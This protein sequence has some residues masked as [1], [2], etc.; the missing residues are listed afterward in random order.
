MN[1]NRGSMRRWVSTLLAFAVTLSLL[2]TS[3]FS[4]AALAAL[5]P[6][7]TETDTE[8]HKTTAEAASASNKPT[9]YIDFLGDS[10]R[11]YPG[12]GS[13]LPTTTDRS[14]EQS[15][16]KGGTWEKYSSASNEVFWIGVGIDKMS[17]FELAKSG[18]GLSGLELGFYY[19]PEFVEPYTNGD[20][21]ATLSSANLGNANTVNQWDRD[22]YYIEEA[23]TELNP[24]TDPDTQEYIA[25]QIPE[26]DPVAYEEFDPA[27]GGWRMLYVSLERKLNDAGTGWASNAANR[28]ADVTSENDGT[29]YY[30]MMLPFTLKKYDPNKAICFRLARNASLFSMGGGTYGAETYDGT[31]GASTFGAWEGETRTPK[32]NLK[33]MFDFEGDLNIFT[34][35][36]ELSR[37]FRATLR[38]VN[39]GGN[40]A[41]LYPSDD[42]TLY[43]NANGGVISGLAEGTAMTL[44]ISKDSSVTANITITT[45]DGTVAYSEVTKGEKYTFVMPRDNVTVTVT[46]VTEI[47][48]DNSD[49]KAKLILSGVNEKTENTADMGGKDKDGNLDETNMAGDPVKDTISVKPGETVTVE[50]ETHPDY[51]ARVEVK[52]KANNTETVTGPDEEGKY[53]FTMPAA[54][55]DVTVTYSLLPTHI[56]VLSVEQDAANGSV[57]NKARLSFEDYSGATADP[58][59]IV[60]TD[61]SGSNHLNLGPIPENRTVTLDVA[62][63]ENYTVSKVELWT[64][65]ENEAERHKVRDL[66]P[67]TEKTEPTDEY[68]WTLTFPMPDYPVEVYVG[69]TKVQDYDAKLVLVGDGMG[70]AVMTGKSGASDANTG[71]GTSNTTGTVNSEGK[72]TIKIQ[73]GNTGTVTITPKTGY[74]IASVKIR[75]DNP[76]QPSLI[77][78]GDYKNG[79]PVT[80]TMPGANVT[81]TVTFQEIYRERY[82]A[83]LKFVPNDLNSYDSTIT[84]WPADASDPDTTRDYPTRYNNLAGDRL[85]AWIGV[86][87]G[88]YIASMEII[89]RDES[90]SGSGT[91]SGKSYSPVSISGNGYNNGAG[92]KVTLV[93]DQ[94]AENVTVYL[95]LREGPP[96][97]EPEQG[98]ILMV[99]DP[100]NDTDAINWAKVSVDGGSPV[101]DGSSTPAAPNGVIQSYNGGSGYTVS[102]I[103]AG[104]TVVVT[105]G[106]DQPDGYYVKNVVVTPAGYGVVPTWIVTESGKPAARFVQPAGP[107][108]VTVE[109]AK[110]DPEDQL[111]ATLHIVDA[112]GSESAT[113]TN[114]SVSP[115]VSTSTD[116]TSIG[117]WPTDVMAT[118]VTTDRHFTVEVYQGG[119]LVPWSA[120]VGKNGQFVMPS[121]DV[122]VYITFRDTPPTGKL[123]TLTAWDVDTSSAVEAAGTAELYVEGEEFPS[124]AN[125]I[126]RSNDPTMPFPIRGYVEDGKTVKVVA[127]P[128]KGY[129]VDHITYT[130]NG[131]VTPTELIAPSITDGTDAWVGRAV[132]FTMPA[133]ATAVEVWFREGEAEK[134][135]ANITLWP[136]AGVTATDAGDAWFTDP[137]TGTANYGYSVS[138]PAGTGLMVKA[139]A[140]DGYYITKIEITPKSLGI[141]SPI[142]GIFATQTVSFVM[143]NADCVV[144]IYYEAGWPDELRAV[145]NVHG[146]DGVPGNTAQL[147][148]STA[149]PVT[150]TAVLTAGESE[151]LT[152]VSPSDVMKVKLTL[153]DGYKVDTPISIKDSYST[154]ISYWWSDT[155][156]ISF[157]MPGT[158]TTVDVTFKE[159]TPETYW[160][161]VVQ[162]GTANTVITSGS[163]TASGANAEI[164]GL[165]AGET[166]T[167]TAEKSGD[168]IPVV[169]VMTESGVPITSTAPV[170]KG[171]GL[172]DASFTMQED[173]AKI[174]IAYVSPAS[175]DEYYA[176][177]F[178]TQQGEQPPPSAGKAVMAWDSGAKTTGEV[179]SVGNE[180]IAIRKEETVTITT[181]PNAGYVVKSVKVTDAD[182][183]TVPVTLTGVDPSGEQTYTYTMPEK[184]VSAVV[185]FVKWNDEDTLKAQIVVNNAGDAGNK[186]VLYRGGSSGETAADNG[187]A[188]LTPLKPADQ[189]MVGLTVAPGFRV[190]LIT[191]TPALGGTI[192]VTPLALPANQSQNVSFY[193]PADDVIVYVRYAPDGADR[194]NISMTVVD[195]TTPAANMPT[196]P[197]NTAT[198]HTDF[199]GTT[200]PASK[201]GDA[202]VTVKGAAA[203]VVTVTASPVD[204]YYA[205]VTAVSDDSSAVPVADLS[206]TD[207]KIFTFS[208]PSNDV[209]VV[210]EFYN[211]DDV[212]PAKH[213]VT[214]HITNPEHGVLA[215]TYVLEKDTASDAT[216]NKTDATAD[217]QVM[218]IQ[219]PYLDAVSVSAKADTGKYI[220]S[221]YVKRGGTSL[222]PVSG[223]V[224]DAKDGG[225][226]L[227]GRTFDFLMQDGDVDVYVVYTD[228]PPWGPYNVALT[229]AGPSG[230][231][232]GAAGSATLKNLAS[233]VKVGPVKSNTSFDPGTDSVSAKDT[234]TFEVRI[235]T[236]PGYSVDTVTVA[237]LSAGVLPTSTTWDGTNQEW[238]YTY[239]MSSPAADM[240]I[241]VTLKSEDIDRYQVKLNLT[242]GYMTAHPS[243]T[244][245]V[246]AA[247]VT[248]TAYTLTKD[249]ETMQV[250]DT[251][252]VT[253]SVKPGRD[254]TKNYYVH[255]A[256][257]L[258]KGGKLLP[259]KNFDPDSISSLQNVTATDT[260][261]AQLVMPK[262]SVDV[263]I[264][265]RDASV[266]PPVEA[267]SAVLT[268]TDPTSSGQSKVKME[269]MVRHASVTA[270]SNGVTSLPIS[271]GKDEKVTLNWAGLLAPGYGV[272]TIT[273]TGGATDTV[274]TPGGSDTKYSFDMPDYDIGVIVKLKS[275]SLDDFTATLHIEDH[276]SALGNAAVMKASGGSATVTTDGGKLTGL[277]SSATVTTTVSPKPGAKV[278]AVIATDGEGTHILTEADTGRY[279]YTLDS[280]DVDIT[281]IF[282]N[283]PD[284]TPMYLATVEKTG[285]G[286]QAG[287]TAAVTN[288]TDPALPKG[289]IW[290]GIYPKDMLQVDVGT[291]DGYYASITAKTESGTNISVL[292]LGTTGTVTGYLTV[293]ADLA[294]N[295]II[296]VDYSTTEPTDPYNLTLRI[297]STFA[298][299]TA[300]VVDKKT[301]GTDV[302]LSVAGGISGTTDTGSVIGGS[303]LVLSKTVAAGYYLK[304]VALE[305]GGVKVI[306]PLKTGDFVMPLSNATLTVT[307]RDGTRTARPHDWRQHPTDVPGYVDG[308]LKGENLSGNQARIRIPNLYD[309]SAAPSDTTASNNPNMEY[310]LYVRDGGS[311]HLLVRGTDYDVT[312]YGG[313]TPADADN[314]AKLS[315]EVGWEYTVRSLVGESAL[316]EVLLNGGVLYITATDTVNNRDESEFVEVT[317]PADPN[318]GKYTA[319][320]RIVDTSGVSGNVAQMGDG[321]TTVSANGDKI[322]D[323]DGDELIRTVVTPATGARISAVTVSD[324]GGTRLLTELP[325]G[326][327][328]YPYNMTGEDIIV[329]VHFVPD[330]DDDLTRYIASVSKRGAIGVAGNDATIVNDTRTDLAKGT[331]WAE[332]HEGDGMR[333]TVDIAEGYYATVTAYQLD[334]NDPHTP[335]PVTAFGAGP[336]ASGGSQ[337]DAILTMPKSPDQTPS[338]VQVVVTYTTEKP[339]DLEND[340]VL[341][342]VNHEEVSGNTATLTE[343][344]E[345]PDSLT[346]FGS[347]TSTDVEKTW[348]A[349]VAV[350][351]KFD[352]TAAAATTADDPPVVYYVKEARAKIYDPTGTTLLS[353][354]AI[355]LDSTGKGLFAMPLGK[356]EVEVV[357]GKDR[358]P[359]PYDPDHDKDYKTDY[360]P[361]S[362]N[363]LSSPTQAGWIEAV[364]M[365]P[366]DSGKSRIQVTVPALHDDAS[367]DPATAL[368][369][370]GK[371]TDLPAAV[372]Q[373]YWKN[374]SGVYQELVIGTDISITDGKTVN[375]SYTYTDSSTDPATVTNID[376][377]GYQFT[378]TAL[379]SGSM[380]DYYIKEGGRIYITATVDP[381]DES[382]YTQIVIAKLYTATLRFTPNGTAATMTDGDSKTVTTDGGTITQ[383][384]G[385]ETITVKEIT[386]AD[387]YSVAG[388]VATTA[389]G[390]TNVPKVSEGVYEYPMNKADVTLQ[391]VYTAV[392]SPLSEKGPHI[393]T[394]Y[395][396]GD[397]GL[398]GNDATVRDLD[399]TIPDDQKGTIW[400]AAY[401]G[402]VVRV[403]A[404]TE[405]GY[406]A[407]ITAVQKDTLKT[408]VPV[409]QIGSYGL[410]YM[411]EDYDV[412]VTVGYKKGTPPAY[413]LSLAVADHGDK[414]ANAAMVN[415]DLLAANGTAPGPVTASVTANTTLSLQTTV[416]SGYSVASAKLTTG[417]ATISIPLTD[418]SSL[419]DFVMP[420]GDAEILVTFQ[421]KAQTPRPYDP[422]HSKKYNTPDYPTD[423]NPDLST[424]GQEGWI[425][426]ATDGESETFTIPVPTLHD[427]LPTDSLHHAPLSF[428]Y[429]LYW[430]DEMGNFVAFTED[431]ITV[432]KADLSS[433]DAYSDGTTTFDGTLL[434]VKLKRSGDPAMPTLWSGYKLAE[435]LENGGSIYI[436]A[437]GDLNAESE[438]T[439]VVIRTVPTTYTA[440]LR[441][442]PNGSSAEMTDGTTSVTDDGDTITGLAG[443]ET[444]T[445][446]DIVPDTGFELVGVV[447][448]TASG[449]VNVPEGETAGEYPYTM[450]HEDVTLRAVYR[451][452]NDPLKEKGPYIVTVQ[453]AGETDGA[454]GNP[455]VKDLDVTIPN[456]QKG[457]IWTAA[458]EGNAVRVDVPIKDGYYALITAAKAGEPVTTVSVAQFAVFDKDDPTKLTAF[459]GLLEMPDYDVDVTVTYVEG[460]L[461]KYDLT[462]KVTETVTGSGTS[463]QTDN[464]AAVNT[465]LLSA[466]GGAPTAGPEQ[467]K[468]GTGLR[469]TTGIASGWSVKGATMKVGGVT[470]DVPLTNGA[471]LPDL[472]MPVG[473]AE[474]EVTF[475]DKA[476]TARPYDPDHS[477]EYNGSGD[478]AAYPADSNPD[479]SSTH[480][481]GWIKAVTDGS[482]TFTLVVRTLYD[483]SASN[484]SADAAK[485]SA[486]WL[487]DGNPAYTLYWRDNMGGYVKFES[488]DITISDGAAIPNSYSSLTGYTFKVTV[489]TPQT[490]WNGYTLAEYLKNGGSIYITATETGKAESEK[491]EVVIEKS[492]TGLLPYDPDRTGDANYIDHWIR[493]ENRGNY[494]VVTVPML[495]RADGS[496]PTEIDG[497]TH[498]LQL[499]LQIDGTDRSS[500]IVNVSH[501]LEMAHVKDFESPASGQVNTWYEEGWRD[502]PTYSANAYTYDDRYENDE[503]YKNSSNEWYNG[504]RFI[505]TLKAEPKAADYGT[506]AEYNADKAAWDALKTIL[507]ENDGT[508]GTAK[509]RLY[510]TADEAADPDN[511]PLPTFASSDYTDLQVP[512]VYSLAGILES[513]APRHITTFTLYSLKESGDAAE[514]DDYETEPEMIFTDVRAFGSGLWQLDFALKSSELMGEKGTG[515][516]YKLVIE[517]AGHVPYTLLGLELS[518]TTLD[519]PTTGTVFTFVEWDEEGNMVLNGGEPVTAI[520]PMAGGDVDG[521]GRV[522][523]EDYFCLLNYTGGITEWSWTEDTDDNDWPISVY[524]PES[525]AYAADATGDGFLGLEDAVCDLDRNAGM[526]SEDYL[527]AYLK[528]APPPPVA[529]FML[530]SVQPSQTSVSET[531]AQETLQRLVDGDITLDD[532]LASDDAK[533]LQDLLDALSADEPELGEEEVAQVAAR[534]AELEAQEEPASEDA[535]E[536][537]DQ[538]TE[539]LSEEPS[540]DATDEKTEQETSI[541]EEETTVDKE[542]TPEGEEQAPTETEEEEPGDDETG[543]VPAAAAAGISDDEG[544]TSESPETAVIS[545]GEDKTTESGEE[546]EDEDLSQDPEVPEGPAEED[547]GAHSLEEDATVDS[548]TGCV[549]PEEPASSAEPLT[550][551]IDVNLED[552]P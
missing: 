350:G 369:D 276:S 372:Y 514:P 384:K 106:T 499:H 232:V 528:S 491:T 207:G 179:E 27:S 444:V 138:E 318:K 441:F 501:L 56:A 452:A 447:A 280:H 6:T 52:T 166:V 236:N 530:F 197:Y 296:T 141:A 357:F 122:H 247:E 339:D 267:H 515:A 244:E 208:V 86:E 258:T 342:L 534:I 286:D 196:S 249:G 189:V 548:S 41:A 226:N 7:P 420:M 382:D 127:K 522:T 433:A 55:V 537:T 214:L 254:G 180:T 96:D 87:P 505:V 344:K 359:R 391:V 171:S 11:A 274:I 115:T 152:P 407:L 136:P 520:L 347:A 112:E 367:T 418:G 450:K 283:D 358:G 397:D 526:R 351:E 438:K 360:V 241:R 303:E 137:A 543:D 53:T 331:I 402:N 383:L 21:K 468:A 378:L 542:E 549:G 165:H 198:I 155:D 101:P 414:S 419:P 362:A 202:A 173:N 151:T 333:V 235:K 272:D 140:N 325:D 426:A 60:V 502:A 63:A 205:K 195:K 77:P 269:E 167:V 289:S 386:P 405:I 389:S 75:T 431:D 326:T 246:N 24:V 191:A 496:N 92:G 212:P 423:E 225:G 497:D 22:T 4:G 262:E 304:E 147:V 277:G 436:T 379:T 306:L 291:G 435:Y 341:R 504:A 449:T 248:Y 301:G 401:E 76:L 62:L 307:V 210:V 261:A 532:L 71:S 523:V 34:G 297:L 399:V 400:T 531:P 467:V 448:M 434:T 2:G 64:Y 394:V 442:M 206:T 28:F 328:H 288:T 443:T 487:A 157:T 338:D 146:D 49:Y 250:P 404:T 31:N 126:A 536:E 160:A 415:T 469:L 290:T 354:I 440:E 377:I 67:L 486:A 211:K 184:K 33:E 220:Q 544:E 234:D 59:T 292:Q 89:G 230:E 231:P 368:S 81:V 550:T 506:D 519:T 117:A 417:G 295:V 251:Q 336:G 508:M 352:L 294:E 245:S 425:F 539:E 83:T 525:Q 293:P 388:V 489:K 188:L 37:S 456:T 215:D 14:K 312:T 494:L 200:N 392:D 273:I 181:T 90:V 309:E 194:Y 324:S 538:E 35:K 545:E 91:G 259:L 546:V 69:F 175:E 329:T 109:F 256:Y 457:I 124:D 217:P 174:A 133:D 15:G 470:I 547:S 371:D 302:S 1:K 287:N 118:S 240:E 408:A 158:W 317:I 428:T 128:K 159:G 482:D 284:D 5:V 310:D 498:R 17:A 330:N 464:R 79:E 315:G 364:P 149:D 243:A 47:K 455:T 480:Q 424:T 327:K 172:Y 72:A 132:E 229:V 366:D 154:A 66:L 9:L 183:A 311:Y 233:T 308:Y 187:K 169:M 252:L 319:T 512:K 13:I 427:A 156:E 507:T 353:T 70:S 142:T 176:T 459:Y 139:H 18:K 120:T 551:S 237:P 3:G 216:P 527:K 518:P 343:K 74:E 323:L 403:D 278:V 370:A 361:A 93:L 521:D 483:Y 182:G 42:P 12:V 509:H 381:K 111:K 51:Q 264:E 524:N 492:T 552:A 322:T 535:E 98:L 186:A 279:D 227:T 416:D 84:G 121:G 266:S 218:T 80:F 511:D 57:D 421:D 26:S 19:N 305:S 224:T 144:N 20:Y 88:W 385:S 29:I 332:G 143:P 163:K 412:D 260:G 356:A 432:T 255:H 282:D 314:T 114:S 30:V 58:K 204:G 300:S 123:L 178:A 466:N 476:K 529:P 162:N 462:L 164:T 413:T 46:Y 148:D 533:Q 104:Q 209:K 107:A 500:D 253:I 281:V 422:E 387:G 380:V 411:P 40:G 460:E 97:P 298:S 313:Y 517:K 199:S 495:N 134:Y 395:K 490:L 44:E 263:Y 223:T 406:Y 363:D 335:V 463:G 257:V 242:D 461:P 38:L 185:T 43:V 355:P 285:E 48:D 316:S 265:F 349:K 100:D 474:I 201:H 119:S 73:T 374:S 465:D 453:K 485:L 475:V 116:N 510:I 270:A 105:F 103:S 271:V 193:M 345:T 493:A 439:E 23:L 95:E 135:M 445:M 446:K 177:L 150:S 393:V 454:N 78:Q 340:L 348:P 429:K 410:F 334:S 473:N 479:L 25:L 130:P 68:K 213:N 541:D 129:V 222:S 346:V 94:P 8:N 16:D 102:D 409:A 484:T 65:S 145:L 540:S 61:R 516:T 398:S 219:V 39:W 203:E 99:S 478:P 82:N 50:V 376:R 10:T 268:V 337:F 471:S 396:K 321:V 275:T 153:A 161:K 239:P 110:K 365:D 228:T 168:Y 36:N 513:Y 131:A 45:P 113:L 125:Y 458:Y 85:T 437:T 190:D 221:V 451:M 320:L 108:T 299:N 170:A 430:K 54:D 488:D 390:S 503:Y 192:T 238:V 477:V 472:I 32:H 373:F 375:N 481:D